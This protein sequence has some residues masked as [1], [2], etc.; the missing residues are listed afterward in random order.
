MLATAFALA[1]LAGCRGDGGGD[2]RTCADPDAGCTLAETA[3]EAGLFAGAA[4]PAD[5]ADPRMAAVPLHFNSITAE[6]AMKWGE[7]APEVGRYDFSEADGLVDFAERKGLRVRGHVLVWGKFPGHGHPADLAAG[8]AGAPDPA[9]FAAEAIRSHVATVVGRYAGRVETWDVVNE[10]LAA[11]GTAFE[12]NLFHEAM[13]PDY[14]AVAFRAAR[15][16]DP[17]ARLVLNEYFSDYDGPKAR[18]FVDLAA[19]LLHEGVPVDG[20][21][22]QG[23]LFTSVPASGALTAFL[24]ALTNLGLE[25]EITEADVTRLALAGPLL[26]GERLFAAQA[27]AYR[28]LTAACVDTP[29][30]RGLTVWGIDDGH[31]WLD[32]FAPFDLFAPNDPLLLDRALAPK[33]AYFAVLD[34]LARVLRE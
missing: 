30:C 29:G 5:L 10:P 7:L 18:A 9:A 27:D 11:V 8:I 26:A 32:R 1:A 3:A 2:G 28:A 20:V 15:R 24:T 12:A 21:G 19:R 34:E 23:H 22:V 16:A 14:I 25:V 13:G 17:G 33:P 31:S 6:N 4:V